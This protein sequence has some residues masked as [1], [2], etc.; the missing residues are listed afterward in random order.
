MN[1]LGSLESPKLTTEKVV[2]KKEE[3]DL[4]KDHE[5]EPIIPG[6]I[7]FGSP[8]AHA[9]LVFRK[10]ALKKRDLEMN[11]EICTSIKRIYIVNT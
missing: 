9:A 3:I 7:M 10:K 5:E 6:E 1:E 8:E 11:Q 4:T 2:V